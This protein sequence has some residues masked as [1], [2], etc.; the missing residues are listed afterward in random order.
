MRTLVS[1]LIV[2]GYSLSLSAQNIKVTGSVTDYY[3][4]PLSGAT[5]ELS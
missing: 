3:N 5:I 2:L 1:V 4:Q